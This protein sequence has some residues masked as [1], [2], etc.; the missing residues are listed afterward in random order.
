MMMLPQG[1]VSFASALTAAPIQHR[2]SAIQAATKTTLQLPDGTRIM[3]SEDRQIQYIAY[4]S[5]TQL[6]KV[7]PSKEGTT[8]VVRPEGS[9]LMRTNN[10]L[11]FS[12]D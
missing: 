3:N 8:I 1:N 2:L 6:A 5:G 10:G 9:T 4:A 11:W 7:G 12:V